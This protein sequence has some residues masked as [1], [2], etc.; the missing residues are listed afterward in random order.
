[1]KNR[2][3][4]RTYTRLTWFC[5]RI[6]LSHLFFDRTIIRYSLAF[7]KDPQRNDPPA[8]EYVTSNHQWLSFHSLGM[9]GRSFET[10]L[11]F[12]FLFFYYFILF[13]RSNKKWQNRWGKKFTITRKQKTNKVY[14]ILLLRRA[15]IH[16]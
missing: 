9:F 5:S 15:E 16:P 11:K 10:S 1:M 4:E 7:I 8:F 3:F 2:L 6:V 13:H 14:S 12:F